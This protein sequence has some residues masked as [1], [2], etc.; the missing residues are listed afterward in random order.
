LSTALLDE[1]GIARYAMYVMDYSAPVGWRLAL[2]HPEQVT[3]LIVQNGN[4][5]DEGL[6]EF[7]DPIKAYWSDHSEAHRKALYVLVAPETTKFQY[8]DGVTDV[9]RIS[10]SSFTCWTPVISPWRT[11][12]TKWCP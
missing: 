1:L 3:G 5:Y 8:T 9:S 2:K 12:P 6:K 11:S 7:W 4:A 10:T